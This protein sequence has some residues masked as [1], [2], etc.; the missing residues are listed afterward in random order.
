MWRTL[1]LLGG[2]CELPTGVNSEQL[3]VQVTIPEKIRSITSGDYESQVSYNIIIERK[4][5]T[6]N[7]VQKPFLP[8]NFKI[9]SYDSA[10]IVE[11]LEQQFQ[12]FCYYQGHVEGYPNS[13]VIVST[14]TG[15][16]GL[17]QFG[18]VSYGIEP[19]ESSIGFEHVI[20]QL[21]HKNIGS[22]LYAEKE[23]ELRN[24]P[25]KIQLMQTQP[26]LFHFIEMHVIVEKQLYNHIGSDAAIVTQKIFQLIGLVNAIFTSF[27]LTVIL[28]SLEF[29]ID[30]N[31][32][33]TTGDANELLHRFLEWKQSYLVL[34]SHDIAFLLVYRETSNYVGATF[35][36]KMCD[37]NYSGGVAMHPRAI[38]LESLAIVLAQL[39]SFSMGIAYD[40]V[41]K[42]RCPGSICIMNPE[43]IHSSGVKVF[44]NCSME[45]FGNFISSQKSQ[46][47]QNQ[48]QLQLSYRQAAK[49]GNGQVEPGEICDCG[50]SKKCSY[51]TPCCNPATC[52]LKPGSVCANGPCCENCKF[53][54][55]G[56]V[57]RAASGECDVAEYCNGTSGECQANFFVL[58]G[59]PCG[60]NKWICMDGECQNGEQQCLDL[61]GRDSGFGSS[62][63]F[64]ELNSKNDISGNC[65]STSAGYTACAPGD[66]K[67]GKLICKYE[68]D[69]VIKI[70]YA[71]I[72]YANVS[73]QMCVS[74]DFPSN[75]QES[76]KMWVGEGTVCGTKKVCMNKRCVAIT[77]LGYDCTPRTCNYHGVC[78][79]KKNCH[80]DPKYLPPN[81]KS[82]DNSW[83]GGSIN[84]GNHRMEIIPERPY[85]E[86]TYHPQPTRWPFFLIIPVYIILC[87]LI[88]ILVKIRLQ[89][90]KRTTKKYPSDDQLESESEHKE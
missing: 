4:T 50:P 54:A 34:R 62:E 66:L 88:A 81:C 18:N 63:C 44:S 7:L 70:E 75:R 17:L 51:E 85:I 82:L 31:K 80:C 5:Y 40:D 28:S 58:N 25:Y 33:A 46:C 84:S 39:L 26:E 9:Y 61:F 68:S 1:L 53:K 86:N 16:R 87:V 77:N 32:I 56:Q 2:L 15:L 21:E 65:G 79:N 90:S 73:G 41:T 83:P 3:H 52:G 12:N 38:S 89:R 10:G 36:G 24:L 74:V 49:C 72:I 8:K 71:T 55:K 76:S 11:I 27:N 69:I 59:H 67:C 6:L 60:K 14:C 30:E 47:L 48:P 42:C 22:S 13:L 29:W 43:A 78:N 45:D 20:Y 37:K 23:I 35:Q 19:L 64:E 57:C